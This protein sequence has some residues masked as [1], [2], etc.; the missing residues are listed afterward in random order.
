MEITPFSARLSHFETPVETFTPPYNE[1]VRWGAEMLRIILYTVC[2]RLSTANGVDIC[3]S[4][5]ISC[6]SATCFLPFIYKYML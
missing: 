4:S 5:D 2:R 3:Y 6:L 1:G